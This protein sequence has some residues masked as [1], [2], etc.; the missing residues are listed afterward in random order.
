MPENFDGGFKH[1]RIVEP[2][3]ITLDKIATFDPEHEQQ[4]DF[5]D[6]MV[7]QFDDKITGAKGEDVVLQTWLI[8]DGYTFDQQPE[9][10]DFDGY[11]AY[12]ID[13]SLLYIIRQDWGNKQTKKLLNDVGT[14]NLNLNTIIVY[15]YSFSI[16]SLRELVLG[17]KQSLSRQVLI[18]RRY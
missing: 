3:V 6:D 14:H 2:D 18:E 11:Q 13:Q 10:I 17:V 9:Q 1:Y 12:Y 5:F 7:T 15:G 4:K 8:H 16:E